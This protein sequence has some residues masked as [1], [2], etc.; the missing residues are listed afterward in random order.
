MGFV[1]LGGGIVATATGV[2][3]AP[4]A[5]MS[6][7]G[8][9]AVAIGGTVTEIGTQTIARS[10]NSLRDDIQNFKESGSSG[11]N[12][13]TEIPERDVSEL[14]Q[15]VQDSFNKYDKA[16]WKG[17]VSGQTPGT[18]AGA[19]YNNINGR[20]PEI[21][22]KGNKITYREFDVN[23]KITGM[24]RDSERF[25]TGSDG[26]IYYTNSHYGEKQIGDGLV[27][28]IKLK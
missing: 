4:G 12:E 23:N 24:A 5:V 27:E 2:G 18:A 20:L 17:N 1:S 14:P 22:T 26:S 6:T 7:A 28:F 3:A 19:K 16:G 11:T 25:V 15:N 13:K 21:D 8:V 10:G 9:G